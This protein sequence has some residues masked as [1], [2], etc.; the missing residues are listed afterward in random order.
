MAQP[1]LA[2][3]T[4]GLRSFLEDLKAKRAEDSAEQLIALLRRRQITHPH[5]IALATIHLLRSAVTTYRSAHKT[6]LFDRVNNIGQRLSQALP[7]E[8]IVG[9]IVRRVLTLI[10]EEDAAAAAAAASTAAAPTATAT[11]TS[12]TTAVRPALGGAGATTTTSRIQITAAAGAPEE[13][14]AGGGTV[15]PG[16]AVPAQAPPIIS[17][18]H[19]LAEEDVTVGPIATATAN[20]N[21]Q[22]QARGQAASPAP[23]AMSATTTTSTTTTTAT[24]TATAASSPPTPSPPA[25][26]STSTHTPSLALAPSSDTPTPPP[27]PPPPQQQQRQTDVRAEVIDG[28]NEIIDELSQVDDQIAAYA[29]EHIHSNEVILTYGASRTVQRFL[30]RAAAKRRF[31]VIHVESYPNH[32]TDT[33][34]YLTGTPTAGLDE[35]RGNTAAGALLAGASDAA[36]RDGLTPDSFHKTLTDHGI[37]VILVPDSAVFAL[38]S[39]V[40]KVILGTHCVLANGA[41]LAPTGARLVANA[42]KVH[43]TPVLVV[44]GIYKVSPVYPFDPETFISYGDS[45]KVLGYEDGELVEKVDV[46]NP[47]QDYVPSDLIDLFVTN[48]GGF[49]PSYLYRI[50]GDQYRQEDLAI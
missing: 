9:N 17:M 34:A 25:P 10:R 30:L 35:A 46:Q 36:A 13:R 41:L 24:V 3:M 20:A 26:T 2:N 40:N 32:H 47:L 19:V 5:A 31:T 18:F 39:R 29:P 12:A 14:A 49:P 1:H 4:P 42:A 8:M 43:K 33:H 6:R 21:A 37:T 11:T 48:I 38:M 44:A 7:R 23:S 15:H 50:L 16:P 28:I 27:P 45:S 22:A